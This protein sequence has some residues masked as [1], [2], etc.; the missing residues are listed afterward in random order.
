MRRNQ[1]C[2]GV[3]VL[4]GVLTTNDA[5]ADDAGTTSLAATDFT[6]TLASVD[7]A[8]AA[9]TLTTDEL[10]STFSLARCAC[11][12][13]VLATLTL[14]PTVAAT[15]GTHV[16]DAQLMIGADCD[17]SAAPGC[18]SVGATLTLSTN[19][20]SSGA[21]VATSAIFDAA[22][23]GACGAASATSTRLW[24]IVRLDGARL[25]TEPSLALTLGGAGP[26]GPTAVKALSADQG[27]LVSWTPTGDS[28]TL[29]GHQVLCSPGPVKPA[30]PSYDACG[31]AVPDGGASPFAALDDALVCSDLVRVG[32]NSVRVHG[33][34]NGRSYQI[35]VVAIGVDATPSAPSAAADGTP[36]PT[37]GFEELY[38]QGG[39]T[40][41]EG[42]A[43]AGAG[44]PRAGLAAVSLLGL[45]LA[46]RR[47]RARRGSTGLVAL[48]ALVAAA[49]VSEPQAR[50]DF[51]GAA[52]SLAFSDDAPNAASPRRWNLEL[53]FGP[54]R[55]D[56][57]SEFAARG[58]DA[59][60]FEQLFSSS[61]RLM[62][63]LELDRQLLRRAGGTWAVGFGAGYYKATAAA[64]AADLTTRTGDETGLRL[65][66]LSAAVVYRAD[67]LRE[68]Y[69]S[70]LV[71]YVKLGLDCALW[72]ATDTS[73]ASTQGRT[74]GWHAAAG[75]TLDL[76]D[77]DPEAA[78][79]MDRESGINETAA[80]FEV[81]RYDLDGFGSG[82]A[83][84][85][86]DTTWFAGLMLEL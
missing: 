29:R 36:A 86:G 60:P 3:L 39:G 24:A 74:F 2:G 35:A 64:L 67:G 48:V 22:G 72:R 42:C 75:L 52:S 80:F 46:S 79:T 34:E 4:F 56:V 9:T 38:K 6:L 16:V 66:P 59:R 28:T 57:D 10:A 53:R 49:G 1:I 51:D 15:L 84:H 54:Y 47:R 58:Q 43:V 23:R 77:L 76:S 44:S 25:S 14:D 82:S 20:T 31:A 18:A 37:V 62:M 32:T 71:P 50:A 55:P 61:R 73:Q 26:K 70:P 81:A 8:G 13:S 68:R 45:A 17:N 78:R 5:R 12:T 65:I 85:L 30:T 69:G 83:L 21:S 33:L 11:P 63:Q 40:A 19:K 27:L 7:G 41:A